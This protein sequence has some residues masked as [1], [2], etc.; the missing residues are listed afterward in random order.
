VEACLILFPLVSTFFFPPFFAPQRRHPFRKKHITPTFTGVG[1]P[2]ILA[3]FLYDTS[4]AI[5]IMRSRGRAIPPSG[6]SSASLRDRTRLYLFSPWIALE[7]L[8]SFNNTNFPNRVYRASRPPL[9]TLSVFIPILIRY[10]P[11]LPLRRRYPFLFTKSHDHS[12]RG[13]EIQ[14]FHSE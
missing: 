1:C 9:H 2:P 3:F 14:S 6:S 7:L 13:D 4:L 11:L 8:L 10:L 12:S 5:G